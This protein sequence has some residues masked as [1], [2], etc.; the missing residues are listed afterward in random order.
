MKHKVTRT[1]EGRAVNRLLL[2]TTTYVDSVRQIF[3]IPEGLKSGDFTEWKTTLYWDDPKVGFLPP[4]VLPSLIRSEDLMASVFQM[5]A[6]DTMAES[7]LHR[8]SLTGRRLGSGSE[9]FVVAL[10]EWRNRLKS[11]LAPTTICRWLGLSGFN[12]H[13]QELI[14]RPAEGSYYLKEDSDVIEFYRLFAGATLRHRGV[15]DATLE[16]TSLS[17]AHLP[18]DRIPGIIEWT[19]PEPLVTKVEPR[20]LIR[21]ARMFGFGCELGEEASLKDFE[22]MVR[23]DNVERRIKAWQAFAGLRSSAKGEYY[24]DSLAEFSRAYSELVGSVIE[25]EGRQRA[26]AERDTVFGDFYIGAGGRGRDRFLVDTRGTKSAG[27]SGPSRPRA[28]GVQGSIAFGLDSKNPGLSDRDADGVELELS[29]GQGGVVLFNYCPLHLDGNDNLIAFPKSRLKLVPVPGPRLE[30]DPES[31]KSGRVGTVDGGSVEFRPVA[32]NQVRLERTGALP[33]GNSKRSFREDEMLVTISL[34]EQGA[35][36]DAELSA[37]VS[38]MR[39]EDQ[40]DEPDPQAVLDIAIQALSLR[41]KADGEGRIVLKT[42]RVE[43]V[44]T[45]GEQEGDSEGEPR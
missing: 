20:T 3:K 27:P 29:G 11:I 43:T 9:D 40:S 12:D 16:R 10:E 45:L 35:A 23:H 39:L 2:A 25:E 38:N 21:V 42:V 15:I 31:W 32:D 37:A 1:P 8:R 28:V 7:D 24:G 18:R 14:W 44:G 4:D 19:P 33:W 22:T 17:L 34:A 26:G 13:G 5:E 36:F 30:F 6:I 41:C